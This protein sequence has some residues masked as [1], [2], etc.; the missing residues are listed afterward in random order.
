MREELSALIIDLRAAVSLGRALTHSEV[1]EIERALAA[2]C[3]EPVALP[4]ALRQQLSLEQESGLLVVGVEAGGPAEHGGLLI[5]DIVLALAG[6]PTRH[7]ED[8]R[9]L[10][11]SERIG[12][13]AAVSIVR[14]G[15]SR[16][17]SVTIGE[18]S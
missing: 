15:E 6:Q 4:D 16:E 18:R 13:S 2:Q 11:G 12:Q 17:L 10:L 9:R 8:L 1:D 7:T 3:G 14:A 5:G